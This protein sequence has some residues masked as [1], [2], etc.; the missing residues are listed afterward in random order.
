MPDGTTNVCQDLRIGQ[1][2][3]GAAGI[4]THNNWWVG[5]SDCYRV[6]EVGDLHCCCGNDRCSASTISP[7]HN[8]AITI[9]SGGDVN[10]FNVAS[11]V[12]STDL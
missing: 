6:P 7:F 2:S 10:K 8:Y 1:G 5:S 9:S 12:A 3:Y 11:Y 4:T